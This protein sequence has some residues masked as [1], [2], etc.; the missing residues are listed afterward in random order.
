MSQ[1][2][3]LDTVINEHIKVETENFNKGLENADDIKTRWE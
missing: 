3:E 2:P 1:Q